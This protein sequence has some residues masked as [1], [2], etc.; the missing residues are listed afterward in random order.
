MIIRDAN[1]DDDALAIA[2][3]A[4]KF[5]EKI[6][7]GRLVS[8]NVLDEITNLVTL[9]GVKIYIAE[10]NG[11]VIGGLGVF[12]TPYIWNNEVLTAEE[13]FWWVDDDAPYKT[14]VSLFNTAMKVIDEKNAIP[15]FRALHDSPKG[16]GKM[17]KK[18][19]LMPMETLY[20]RLL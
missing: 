7:L 15:M 8:D 14:A 10:H 16:V 19:G 4:R 20:V 13:L 1:L 6:P 18:Q 12:F 5:A 3:G 11:V 9:P 17:Y 2:E